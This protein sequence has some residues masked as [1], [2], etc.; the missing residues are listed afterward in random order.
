MFF[1]FFASEFFVI[2]SL[3]AKIYDRFFAEQPAEKKLL[4]VV[5]FYSISLEVCVCA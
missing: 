5:E 2:E 4:R 1:S 3:D